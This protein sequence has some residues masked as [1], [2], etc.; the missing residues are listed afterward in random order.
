MGTNWDFYPIIGVV[1][2]GQGPQPFIFTRD[3][4]DYKTPTARCFVERLADRAHYA[5]SRTGE[6]VNPLPREP[7][8]ERGGTFLMSVGV[9]ADHA[10]NREAPGRFMGCSKSTAFGIEHRAVFHSPG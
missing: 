5:W 9:R 10:D 7:T 3:D 4:S 8:T 1:V 6:E 2:F